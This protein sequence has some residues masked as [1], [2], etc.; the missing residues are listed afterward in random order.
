MSKRI[1]IMK[2]DEWVKDCED[3]SL[4]VSHIK[5]KWMSFWVALDMDEPTYTEI[6]WKSEADFVKI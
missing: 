3:N 1:Q 4:V 5:M 6:Y 2:F